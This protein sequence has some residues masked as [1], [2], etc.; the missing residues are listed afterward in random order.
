MTDAGMRALPASE[1]ERSLR[2]V[3]S[4]VED[5]ITNFLLSAGHAPDYHSLNG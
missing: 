3:Q 4:V 1:I 5:K 2:A